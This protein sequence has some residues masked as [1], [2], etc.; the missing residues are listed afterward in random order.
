MGL[1]FTPRIQK[2]DSEIPKIKNS[3]FKKEKFQT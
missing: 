2:C 3:F 1:H